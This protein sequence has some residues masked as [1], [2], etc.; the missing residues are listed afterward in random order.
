MK[1]IEINKMKIEVINVK[2]V[3]S[4]TM[5]ST[6]VSLQVIIGCRRNRLH[7]PS[8]IGVGCRGDEVGE[9]CLLHVKVDC[10]YLYMCVIRQVFVI[11]C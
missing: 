3:S 10:A 9:S 8:Q 4:A 2:L 1:L 7:E 5:I 11:R 6:K